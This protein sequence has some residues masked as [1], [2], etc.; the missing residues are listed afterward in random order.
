L[1]RIIGKPTFALNSDRKVG[2]AG[3]YFSTILAI[4][5]TFYSFVVSATTYYIA[6]NGSDSNSG[7]IIYPFA[8]LNKA[9][10]VIAA[11]DTVYLRGGTY[12]FNSQQVLT[13][14][15]GTLENLIK[16]WAYPDETPKITRTESWTKGTSGDPGKDRMGIY[17]SGNYVHWK[18]IEMIGFKQEDG[19][20]WG[21]LRSQDFNNC[22]FELLNIHHNG[23]PVYFTGSCTGNLILNCDFHHQ[24]DPLTPGEAS[25][26]N[27][28]GLNFENV[29]RYSSNTV[30]GCRAWNVSDDGFDFYNYDGY[31][32]I[33]NCWAWNNGV[34]E[35]NTPVGSGDGNGFKLGNSVLTWPTDADITRTVRN[36]LAFNN[37]HWGFT[38]NGSKLDMELFNNTAYHN[39]Y[40]YLTHG[41]PPVWSP[42]C[43]GFHFDYLGFSDDEGIPYNIKNN[44]SYDSYYCDAYL[45]NITNV[46]HNSWTGDSWPEYNSPSSVSDADFVSVDST[47]VSGARQADGSLPD[48]NYL[49]LISGSDLIDA[50][51][52]VGLPCNGSAPD[53]GAFEFTGINNHYPSIL[54]QSFQVDENSINGTVVGTV[55]ASD[56]DAGQTL[57]YF[58]VSGNT[59]GAFAI[60]A[61]NGELFVA[62]SA[63]LNIDFALV[64]KVQDSGIGELSSQA[65]ITI[66]VVPAGIES[67]GNNSTIKVYPNPVSDELTIEIEG[68]NDRQCFEILNSVG[69]IVF[70]GNLSER[71]VVPT[72]NLSPGVY[73]LKV[74]NGRS[75][76]LKRIVRL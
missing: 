9:W 5:F 37:S 39:G 69:Q 31:V 71:T 58:I 23:G 32:L 1:D 68:N 11:G 75:F 7:D 73:L 10:T 61:S 72:T 24:Q 29:P 25:Y 49:H 74:E 66:N 55:V 47:G 43:S 67:T 54:D 70:K 38:D 52:D 63:A 40:G 76:E 44:I 59:D 2:N 16:V 12:L 20:V 4:I 15:S 45:G 51:I 41:T 56:P 28:D 33:E 8:T 30:R 36:C 42:Y 57:E 6:P 62:N 65:T 13:G 22:I 34:D 27:A 18:G 35:D 14:K 26:N 3:Y 50:G 53:L 64:V 17:F 21:A 60:N 48:I 46:D 19:Y